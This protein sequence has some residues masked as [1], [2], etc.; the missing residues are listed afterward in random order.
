VGKKGIH[1]IGKKERESRSDVQAGTSFAY[2]EKILD[3]HYNVLFPE[4][5]KVYRKKKE[6]RD[7]G[8]ISQDK[9]GQRGRLV[10]SIKVRP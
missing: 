5:R 1:R 7:P 10:A 8:L 3:Q 4:K 2:A 9:S 6:R